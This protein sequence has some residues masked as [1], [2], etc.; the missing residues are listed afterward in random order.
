MILARPPIVWDDVKGHF[1]ENRS[2]A[3]PFVWPLAIAELSEW[4]LCL[5]K[6]DL[7]QRQRRS[8]AHVGW[9]TLPPSRDRGDL[10]AP[11]LSAEYDQ[12]G[13]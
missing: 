9:S 12:S 8:V 13:A 10:L 7:F 3:V 4:A 6:G 1:V 5:K 2:C 11:I